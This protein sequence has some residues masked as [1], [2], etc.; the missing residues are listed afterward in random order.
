MKQFL[1]IIYFIDT[2][3]KFNSTATD[4]INKIAINGG[5]I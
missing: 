2:Y 3:L 4:V 5:G 1:K